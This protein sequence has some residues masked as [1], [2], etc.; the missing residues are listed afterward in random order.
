MGSTYTTP[1]ESCAIGGSSGNPELVEATTHTACWAYGGYDLCGDCADYSD[2]VC[3]G[4][5]GDECIAKAKGVI[6]GS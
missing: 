3:S 2:S 6:D 4:C 5:G 1:C